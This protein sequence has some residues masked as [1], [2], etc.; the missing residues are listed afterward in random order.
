[1]ALA[2]NHIFHARTKHIEI[3]YHFIREHISYDNIH[4]THIPSKEQIADILTKSLSI[5]RFNEL[6]SKL[7]IRSSND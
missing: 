2:K 1:M 4:L 5:A 6:R 3:D 7:T